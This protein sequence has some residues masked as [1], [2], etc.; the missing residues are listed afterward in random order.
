MFYVIVAIKRKIRLRKDILIPSIIGLIPATAWLI[1]N[2]IFYKNPFYP[3]FD[4]LFSRGNLAGN[5]ADPIGPRPLGNER[6][7]FAGLINRFDWSLNS[8][9]LIYE[10]TLVILTV[11][12]SFYLI[13]KY[14]TNYLILPFIISSLML[15][16]YLYW[17]TGEELTRYR[18]FIL[19]IIIYLLLLTLKKDSLRGFIFAFMFLSTLINFS[20]SRHIFIQNIENNL[21]K[22]N[23][24][25]QLSELQ[26]YDQ[27]KLIRLANI[28]YER[29]K[30]L[31][32]GD[33]RLALLPINFRAAD[34]SR[35]SV[36]NSESYNTTEKIV[37]YL[38][39]NDFKIVILSLDWGE[40][41]KWNKEL[42]FGLF[43]NQQRCKTYSYE[44]LQ[45]CEIIS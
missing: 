16:V 44:G 18:H 3:Y 20:V 33:N 27:F 8:Y 38:K 35:F 11:F 1:R 13:K 40:P 45:V 5:L 10:F 9:T 26:S 25:D 17:S 15:Y 30:V 23:L 19:W 36:L 41:A 24:S 12:F 21:T 31:L 22:N 43:E 39:K 42:W 29:E 32:L 34:P 28:N 2:T 6:F 37:D 4:Q 14:W 7:R